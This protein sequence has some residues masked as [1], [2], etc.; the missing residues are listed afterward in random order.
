MTRR[1]VC[2]LLACLLSGPVAADRLT[3]EEALAA[4][5]EAHPDRR[6]AESD[7]TLALTERDLSLIHI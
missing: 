3:L 5:S 7:L 6:L 1:A 4:V 2:W